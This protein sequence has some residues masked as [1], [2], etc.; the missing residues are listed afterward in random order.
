[1]KPFCQTVLCWLSMSF[2][3]YDEISSSNIWT[4]DVSLTHVTLR[5]PTLAL[6]TYANVVCLPLA[7]IASSKAIRLTANPE[8]GQSPLRALRIACVIGVYLSTKARHF[9]FL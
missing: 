4:G 7:V 9:P 3:Q 5:T 2:V 6:S 8:I 1:M